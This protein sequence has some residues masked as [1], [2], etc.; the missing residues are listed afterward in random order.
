MNINDLRKLLKDAENMAEKAVS[1]NVHDKISRQ[2]IEGVKHKKYLYRGQSKEYESI[3]PLAMRED[4]K[5]IFNGLFEKYNLA[6]RFDDIH[7]LVSSI[8]TA[9]I[10]KHPMLQSRLENI[11]QIDPSFYA[12]PILQHYGFP[13]LQLDMTTDIDVALAFAV[14]PNIEMTG[15]GVV[16]RI[17]ASKL[18]NRTI[19]NLIPEGLGFK[20]PERQHAVLVNAEGILDVHKQY[21]NDLSKIHEDIL[22][23]FYFDHSRSDKDF[24]KKHHQLMAKT[25]KEEKFL[26]DVFK[27]LEPVLDASEHVKGNLFYNTMVNLNSVCDRHLKLNL[28]E[29]KQVEI[30]A[31]VKFAKDYVLSHNFRSHECERLLDELIFKIDKS[32]LDDENFSGIAKNAYLKV[33]N[34]LRTDMIATIASC[35]DSHKQAL[36][37]MSNN[38]IS[39]WIVGLGLNSY[40]APEYISN[41]VDA[42][43]KWHFAYRPSLKAISVPKE[44]YAEYRNLLELPWYFRRPMFRSTRL[45]STH[46]N[47]SSGMPRKGEHNDKQCNLI[48]ATLKNA[49]PEV[50][51]LLQNGADANQKSHIGW[52]ALF[53]AADKGYSEIAQALLTN[54][55]NPNLATGQGLVPLHFA[56]KNGHLKVVGALLENGADINAANADGITALLCA[57]ENNHFEIAHILVKRGADVDARWMHGSTA[58]TRAAALNFTHIAVFLVESGADVNANHCSALFSAAEKGNVQIMQTLI[59]AGGNINVKFNK[60]VTLLM[61]AA[62]YGHTDMIKLLLSAGAEVN[63][64]NISGSTAL[65][66]AAEGG[67]KKEEDYANAVSVLLQSGGNPNSQTNDGGTPLIYASLAG[68]IATVRVLLEAGAGKRLK[69]SY[70]QDAHNVAI[71]HGHHEIAKLVKP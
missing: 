68:H 50:Y 23:R 56:A 6:C 26:Y 9:R 46:K 1:I 12:D 3:P 30:N 28:E 43:K 10:I 45:K 40:P 59:S 60:D 64:K 7:P 32:D 58:L 55:A 35:Q 33:F 5:T 54:G 29:F 71:A 24:R 37:K 14:D 2:T 42:L 17:D 4:I 63:A 67:D 65:T 27:N 53:Y 62:Q 38:I 70:G 39:E 22:Q 8:V 66:L 52:T 41:V 47:T 34:H 61:A 11:K 57:A 44:V 21:S 25:F 19:L 49:I 20:R 51:R 69:N 36:P 13:T 31:I 15:T 18:I 48:T 16:Y